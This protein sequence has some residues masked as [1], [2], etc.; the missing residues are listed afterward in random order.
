MLMWQQHLTVSSDTELS[1]LLLHGAHS[2]PSA[3]L[4]SL[5]FDTCHS[6]LPR[7]KHAA[8]CTTQC[9]SL[10]PQ[11]PDGQQMSSFTSAQHERPARTSTW[12]S[13]RDFGSW[14]A[15]GMLPLKISSARVTRAGC[16]T[17]VPSWPLS[18]SRCLSF[19]TCAASACSDLC[20]S[21]DKRCPG[22]ARDVQASIPACQEASWRM[23]IESTGLAG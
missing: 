22:R 3:T 5:V 19:F 4:A 7:N 16:A 2:A 1:R 14:F 23:L 17:Q 15:L 13:E 8:L 18:T 20:C 21:L 9:C 11:L 6:G 10:R 12:T